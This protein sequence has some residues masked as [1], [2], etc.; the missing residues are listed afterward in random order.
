MNLKEAIKKMN[1]Q[2]IIILAS[3]DHVGQL[4]VNPDDLP[5][6]LE[7]PRKF[8]KRY[9]GITEKQYRRYENFI[10]FMED[11]GRCEEITRKGIRCKNYCHW[12]GNFY[13][14]P[15]TDLSKVENKCHLHKKGIKS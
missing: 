2:G 3:F 15:D 7:N 1:D 9:W 11:D 13:P 5:L 6:L 8:W 10:N 14:Q 12:F 4:L